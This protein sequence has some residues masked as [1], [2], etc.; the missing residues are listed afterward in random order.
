MFQPGCVCGIPAFSSLSSAMAVI[1][2]YWPPAA[3]QTP[4]TLETPFALE[5]QVHIVKL[6]MLNAVSLSALLPLGLDCEFAREVDEETYS[7]W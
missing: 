7:T 2:T 1:R 3:V 4:S 5:E 6:G